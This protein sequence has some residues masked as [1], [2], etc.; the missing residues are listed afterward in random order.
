MIRP[1]D[2]TDGD[3]ADGV[4]NKYMGRNGDGHRG[5]CVAIRQDGKQALIE[6]FTEHPGRMLL[7]QERAEG[8][9]P[10]FVRFWDEDLP[11]TSSG[12]KRYGY[13]WAR[14]KKRTWL[15]KVIVTV[16]RWFA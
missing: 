10:W 8:H 7:V 1:G 5:H 9:Y 15:D 3:D 11:D 6:G 2:G 12:W 14:M 4:F 16:R 13:R